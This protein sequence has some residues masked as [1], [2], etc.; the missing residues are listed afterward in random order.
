MRFVWGWVVLGLLLCGDD[1]LAKDKKGK[2]KKKK[3]DEGIELTGIAAFDQVF[4]RVGEIDQRLAAS[5]LEL[6]TGKGNLNEALDLK[7]GTPITN[8]I[9]ELQNRAGNKLSVAV[10]KQAVPKLTADDAVPSDV[11]S[12]MDAVNAMTGNFSTSLTELHA[13]GPEIDGLVKE[14]KKMPS[15]LKDEFDGGALDKLFTLPK[16]SKA[17]THDIGITTGLAD[18]TESLTTRMTEVMTVVRTEFAPAQGGG[19]G[20]KQGGGA[21][22]KK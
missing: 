20:G 11:R 10:N 2:K 22:K 12:A 7:R 15:R 17:L 13:L 1:A 4:A 21:R 6:R 8:G 18:R 5:E 19:G 14:A 3:E 9:A 16:V